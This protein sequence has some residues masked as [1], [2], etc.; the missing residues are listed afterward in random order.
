MSAPIRIAMWSGPRN[1]ST[2]MMRAFEARGDCAVVDE[3]FYA[4]YLAHA[5]VT[6][7][8]HDEVLASQPQRMQDVIAQLQAP[9][10]GGKALQYQKQMAH[11][12]LGNI[13]SDWLGSLRHAFLI[14]DPAAMVASYAQKRETVS[15]VDLGLARQRE[16]YAEVCS[17]TGQMPPIIDAADVLAN[18]QA[19]LRALCAA[20]DI[21]YVGDMTRWPPGLRDTD[22]AWAPHWYHAVAA[23][24]GFE[25]PM[26]RQIALTDTQRSVVDH[27][28]Q[29]Y[30]FLH[31]HRLGVG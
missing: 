8:M 10:P 13:D 26:P 22:G 7:P 4:Y 3:P 14:R 18:P 29:D 9:L 1:I 30:R 31:E 2:A 25:K 28:Y 24:G 17:I 16:I 12:M 15:A 11:H 21:D 19:M 5:G 27:C 20:L 6:H 23:S